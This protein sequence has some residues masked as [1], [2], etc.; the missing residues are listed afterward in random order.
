M[1]LTAQH[2]GLATFLRD[3]GSHRRTSRRADSAKWHYSDS[4]TIILTLRVFSRDLHHLQHPCEV[5]SL[6]DRTHEKCKE[7]QLLMP[8]KLKQTHRRW[9]DMDQSNRLMLYAVH[10]PRVQ[11]KA[12]AGYRWSQVAILFVGPLVCWEGGT[13]VQ[14]ACP[15]RP[16][17]CMP[18][19]LHRMQ[20]YR[21]S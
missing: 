1:T 16:A 4:K 17:E 8:N 15:R 14:G 6:E 12:Q 10:R 2:V 5:V 20:T 3:D 7:P 9:L 13:S 11:G 18:V 21:C 19:V